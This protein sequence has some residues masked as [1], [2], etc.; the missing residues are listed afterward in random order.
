MGIGIKIF[1]TLPTP[2]PYTHIHTKQHKGTLQETLSLSQCHSPPCFLVLQ[3]LYDHH[4]EPKLL[5]R[6]SS[7]PWINFSSVMMTIILIRF[8]FFKEILFQKLFF[9]AASL[10]MLLKF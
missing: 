8:D 9:L 4:Q 1:T 10:L 6:I 2:A 5:W 7:R 3:V